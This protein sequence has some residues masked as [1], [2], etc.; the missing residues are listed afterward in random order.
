MKARP[1]FVSVGTLRPRL[2]SAAQGLLGDAVI[3]GQDADY[4]AAMVWLAP[5][6][7]ARV[8][9]DGVPDESLRAEL[10]A[11]MQ[12]LAGDGAGSSQRVERLLVLTE[13]AQLDAG[14][15][16]DKGYVNQAAVRARRTDLVARL[17]ADPPPPQVVAR[18]WPDPGTGMST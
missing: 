14:E 10:A 9:A 17:T 16:T 15:I 13:P 4:V 3:C 11:V 1:V 2:L 8:D 5:D 18:T 6:S 7:A 12:Q